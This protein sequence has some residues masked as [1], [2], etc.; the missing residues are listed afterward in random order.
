MATAITQDILVRQG[1]RYRAIVDVSV[2]WLTDLTGYN[3]R[4]MVRRYQTVDTD[5]DPLAELDLYLTVD[6]PNSLV[7]IDIPADV[8][9]DWEWTRG[10]YDIEIFDGNPA[11]DVRVL[12]GQMKVSPEVT[13]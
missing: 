2:E 13:F 10:R 6:G 9:A 3:A 12:E 11:H 7:V 8:S 1:S 5:A 4:G